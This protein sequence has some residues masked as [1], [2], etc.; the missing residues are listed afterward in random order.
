MPLRREDT[1]R[2]PV[3]ND[4][5]PGDGAGSRLVPFPRGLAER[6]PGEH[7]SWCGECLGWEV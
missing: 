4:R 3:A 6:A 7:R 2:R 1:G 5:L